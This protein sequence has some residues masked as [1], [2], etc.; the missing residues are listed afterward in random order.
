MLGAI[1]KQLTNRGRIPEHTRK[2]FQEAKK[3]FGGRGPR[4]PD[5]VDML[6][7]AMT[8]L[9]RLFICI[10]A[11]DECIP[12]NRRELIESLREIIQVSSGARVFITGRPHID[13]E[14]VGCFS[15]T[16]RILLSPT[17]ADIN[18]YLEMRLDSD[19]DPN[20]MDDQLRADI[21]RIVPEK[22]SD[23]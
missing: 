15:K 22:V 23:M 1:L 12:K 10:D 4:L 3:E 16:L 8:S 20:A 18:S 13:D 21:I 5:M 9:P 17:H 2:A 19:T 7:K 6:K 11:L 14:I